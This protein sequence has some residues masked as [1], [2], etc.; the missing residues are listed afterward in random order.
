MSKSR[1]SWLVALV[2]FVLLFAACAPAARPVAATLPVFYAA[3]PLDVMG[4]VILAISTAPGLDDSNGWVIAQSDTQGGYVR[5]ETDVTTPRW[6]LRRESTR[7]ESVTVVVSAAGPNRTQ[8][9]VQRTSGAESLSQH[10]TRELQ[11]R[12]GLN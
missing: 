11:A 6:F 4:V 12:F 9:V 2:P 5:A 8:V 1:T 10:I 3:E 7:T